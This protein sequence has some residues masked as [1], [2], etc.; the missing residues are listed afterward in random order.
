MRADV[1]AEGED[2]GE[3]DLQHG[4]PVVGG[5]LVRRV[6]PLDAAAVDEDVDSVRVGEDAGD[7]G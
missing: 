3:V 5:E 7:E 4:F 1:A 2:R 6:A